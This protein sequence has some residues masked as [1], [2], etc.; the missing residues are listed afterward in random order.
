VHV[1]KVIAEDSP[2]RGRKQPAVTVFEKNKDIASQRLQNGQ[3][4]A[5]A[6]KNDQSEAHITAAPSAAR[7]L[8]VGEKGEG[9]L[10]GTS[11]TG[12]GFALFKEDESSVYPEKDSF[13]TA[14]QRKD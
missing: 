12:E 11:E 7:F 1:R 13:R 8:L 5:G 9:E 14:G 3:A 6:V 4:T 2:P 10:Y